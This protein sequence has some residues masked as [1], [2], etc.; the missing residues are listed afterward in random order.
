MI[1]KFQ[2]FQNH[3]FNQL[4][5]NQDNITSWE[6]R[7]SRKGQKFVQETKGLKMQV[8]VHTGVYGSKSG[9]DSPRK[10]KGPKCAS[11]S[12]KVLQVQAKVYTNSGKFKRQCSK[13]VSSFL[14][15]SYYTLVS[16]QILN[17][18]YYPLG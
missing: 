16:L 17:I 15:Q 5:Q 2:T 3:L 14:S 7:V 18:Q 10:V 6:L 11:E 13:V 1:G 4:T 8:K 12:R 9:D